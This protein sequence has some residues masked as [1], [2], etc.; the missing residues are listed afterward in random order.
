MGFMLTKSRD[1]LFPMVWSSETS[2]LMDLLKPLLRMRNK[3]LRQLTR[4]SDKYPVSRH[5]HGLTHGTQLSG[6]FLCHNYRP[7][8]HWHAH[9]PCALPAFMCPFSRPQLTGVVLCPLLGVFHGFRHLLRAELP[10]VL[11]PIP[12]GWGS[13]PE[14]RTLPNR[15]T[16][17][18]KT[19]LLMKRTIPRDACGFQKR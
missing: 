5:L 6:Q 13:I 11:V 3:A 18:R 9:H 1:L 12:P 16:M 7:R 2:N 14:K 10:A 19:L 4:R 15:L 17:I 8:R